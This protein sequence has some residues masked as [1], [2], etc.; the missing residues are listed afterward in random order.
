VAETYCHFELEADSLRCL[1]MVLKSC[2][3]CYHQI[4]QFP[5]AVGPRGCGPCRME[6]EVVCRWHVRSANGSG[7]PGALA[8][9]QARSAGRS[10]SPGAQ[11]TWY[12]LLGYFLTWTVGEHPVKNY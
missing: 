2:T 7:S 12:R 6:R 3:A 8:L 9:L 5:Y 10:D 1:I 11:V 4:D